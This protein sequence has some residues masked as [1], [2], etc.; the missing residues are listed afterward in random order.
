MFPEF[1]FS[2]YEE[3][4]KDHKEEKFKIGEV[5]KYIG[6]E[7]MVNPELIALKGKEFEV[8]AVNRQDEDSVEYL[9][10]GF[11]YLVYEEELEK[12]NNA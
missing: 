8:R 3:M 6:N 10:G 1:D 12:I 5:V 4:W 7:Y 11:P 2:G 9:L